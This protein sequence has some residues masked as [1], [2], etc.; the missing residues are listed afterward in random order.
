ME[1]GDVGARLG[2]SIGGLET[3]ETAADNDDARTRRFRD[4]VD[5][6]DVAEGEHARQVHSGDRELDRLGAG[7]KDELGK[8]QPRAVRQRH[9]ARGRIDRARAHAVA[10]GDAAVA[11]PSRRLELD[12]GEA[13]LLGQQRREQHAIVGEPRLVA[14]HGDGVATKCALGQFLDQTRRR[15]AIADDDERL[16]HRFPSKLRK[17][18]RRCARPRR[19][20]LSRRWRLPI[21]IVIDGDVAQAIS[22]SVPPGPGD[23]SPY[24]SVAW[25]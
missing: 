2:E 20:R 23:L 22:S 4:G 5:V 7:R 24:I 1:D 18:A 10:Q 3:E 11:P 14:D 12:I 17:N 19:A 13:D 9:F 15:H 16:A 21:A 6:V 25:R 8:R